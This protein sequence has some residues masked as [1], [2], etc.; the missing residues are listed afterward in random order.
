MKSKKGKSAVTFI[1]KDKIV[2]KK[3]A[4]QEATTMK[5]PK[6]NEELTKKKDIKEAALSYC[7]DLLTN[8]SPK[9]GFKDDVL[10]TDLVHEKRM[11]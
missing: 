8:R 1:L 2:G 7:V 4:A 10:L 9:P 11:R 6:T 5:D 3:K